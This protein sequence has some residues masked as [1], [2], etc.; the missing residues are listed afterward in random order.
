MCDLNQTTLIGRLA[1]D[2]E[3]RGGPT[4]NRV[5][6]FCLAVNHRYRDTNDRC[7]EE[8]AFVPCTAFAWKADQMAR[9]HKGETVFVSGRLKTETWEKDGTSRSRLVLVAERV[10]LVKATPK[11]ASPESQEITEIQTGSERRLQSV[12]F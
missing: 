9:W 10:H 11:S 7:R 12:P 1:R 3:L 4:G 5:S 8:T 6:Q 2:P